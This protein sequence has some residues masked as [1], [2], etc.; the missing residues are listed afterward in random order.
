M[1]APQRFAQLLDFSLGN[2]L[3]VLGFREL[4]GNFIEIPKNTFEGFADSFHFLPG[5]KNP[6]PLFRG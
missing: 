5:L 6:G 1:K 4:I 2:V 3:F